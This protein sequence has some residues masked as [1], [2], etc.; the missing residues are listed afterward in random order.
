MYNGIG[1]PT[2]RGSGTNGYVQKNV[3]NVNLFGPSRRLSYKSAEQVVRN[4]QALAS[5]RFQTADPDI[6]EHER[7]RRAYV[8]ALELEEKL[9][10]EGILTAEQVEALTTKV[11][12]QLLEQHDIEL[13]YED[14]AGVRE[15]L[16]NVTEEAGKLK[17][18]QLKDNKDN[19]RKLQVGFATEPQRKDGNTKEL[20]KP[21]YRDCD[22]HRKY[23]AKQKENQKLKAALGIG[24]D[25]QPGS[26]FRKETD[27]NNVQEAGNTLNDAGELSHEAAPSQV[28]KAKPV[29]RD[30][31]TPSNGDHASAENVAL[32]VEHDIV[33][34]ESEENSRQKRH[35]RDDSPLRERGHRRHHHRHDESRKRSHREG[36]RRRH[37]H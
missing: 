5:T 35:R 9:K 34:K 19:R 32:K 29:E 23:I 13:A 37:E 8:L 24:D 2:P 1:L 22:I 36:T 25:Y 4:D 28:E 11:K 31:D 18:E 30:N 27:T 3:A 17:K 7:R 14:N 6:L 15:L 12:T 20:D 10:A 21:V 33:E 16:K 26:V